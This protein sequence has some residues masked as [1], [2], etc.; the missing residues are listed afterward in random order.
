MIG[1]QFNKPGPVRRLLIGPN[2]SGDLPDGFVGADI[3]QSSSDFAGVLARVSLTDDTEEE[4]QAVNAIQD[5]ITA[6]SLSQW[7][8]AGR[9]EVKA[10]DV[11]PTKAEYATYPGMEEVREPGKLTGVEFLRWVSLV[12]NDPSFTKQSDGH[13]EILRS[14]ASNA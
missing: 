11:P 5:S 8:A 2:W 7:I 3:V 1:S 12:L 4:V 6:M 14:R 9:K 13:K 10:E